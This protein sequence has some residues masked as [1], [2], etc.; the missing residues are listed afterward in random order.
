MS[1]F[2]VARALRAD[3][4]T[5]GILIAMHTGRSKEEVNSQLADFDLFMPKVDDADAL[6]QRVAAALGSHASSPPIDAEAAGSGGLAVGMLQSLHR[7]VAN[8]A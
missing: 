3:A 8:R 1:R 5:A 6:L 7:R 4:R 2:E